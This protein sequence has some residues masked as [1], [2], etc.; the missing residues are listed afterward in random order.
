M[1]NKITSPITRWI[2]ILLLNY[3]FICGVQNLDCSQ[4]A[5]FPW[6]RRG[7]SFSMRNRYLGFFKHAKTGESTLLRWFHWLSHTG[8]NYWTLIGWDRGHFFLITRALFGNQEGMITW[9]WL[10]ERASSAP[11]WFPALKRVWKSSETQCIRVWY[12][13]GYFIKCERKSV[14][15]NEW[16]LGGIERGLFNPN[17][18]VTARKNFW[19]IGAARRIEI[20][21]GWDH[22][23]DTE[24]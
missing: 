2:T 19:T 1:I 23:I 16:C 14:G 17:S 11:S 13:C 15:R 18:F 5:T 6:S 9:S 4:S 7:R 10:A 20:H 22:W 3:L 8:Q 24:R 21:G 12:K